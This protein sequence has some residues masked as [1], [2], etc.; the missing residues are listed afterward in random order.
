MEKVI[1][2]FIILFLITCLLISSIVSTSYAATLTA[3][4]LKTSLQ[5]MF[6]KTIKIEELS[7]D[8]SVEESITI[9][10]ADSFTVTDSQ[11]DATYTYE[12]E[13]VTTTLTYTFEDNKCVFTAQYENDSTEDTLNAKAMLYVAYLAVADGLELNLPLAYN[14]LEQSTNS[15]ANAASNDKIVFSSVEDDEN[16]TIKLEINTEE[17]AKLTETDLKNSAHTRITLYEANKE[18]ITIESKGEEQTTQEEATKDETTANIEKV[19]NAGI[20]VELKD[21]LTVVII[22]AIIGVALMFIYDKKKSK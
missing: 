16:T 6:A 20:Q 3:E 11:I 2:K 8:E 10:K 18:T 9:S 21:V 13:E 1:K 5:S 12:S 7:D 15:F 4:T 17:L 19:P 22:V 14:Y